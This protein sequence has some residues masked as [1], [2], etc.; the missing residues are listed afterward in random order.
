MEISTGPDIL[1]I[2]AL[3]CCRSFRVT[4]CLEIRISQLNCTSSK[5]C[6][7]DLNTNKPHIAHAD[8]ICDLGSTELEKSLMISAICLEHGG[9]GGKLSSDFAVVVLILFL[10]CHAFWCCLFELIWFTAQKNNRHKD[11]QCRHNTLIV[12]LNHLLSYEL[13]SDQHYIL[14]LYLRY[15]VWKLWILV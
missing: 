14:L 6:N 15:L 7:W 13:R 4:D 5:F 3:I 2:G 9:L 8:S 11:N 12:S 1:H 10:S